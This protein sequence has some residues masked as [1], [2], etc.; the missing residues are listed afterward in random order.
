MFYDYFKFVI[1]WEDLVSYSP[2][3]PTGSLT[4][5]TILNLAVH[6]LGSRCL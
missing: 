2:S 5:L 4:F 6:I 1:N 3:V